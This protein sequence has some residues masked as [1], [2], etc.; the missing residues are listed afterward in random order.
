MSISDNR[1]VEQP[2]SSSG[3]YQRLDPAAI[4]ALRQPP[5]P[6]VYASLSITNASQ[7]VQDTESDNGHSG[8][9]RVFIRQVWLNIRCLTSTQASATRHRSHDRLQ[10]TTPTWSWF[11]RMVVIMIKHKTAHSRSKFVL[12]TAIKRQILKCLYIVSLNICSLSTARFEYWYLRFLICNL[13]LHFMY[14][15]VTIWRTW[16]LRT[17]K[18]SGVQNSGPENDGPNSRGGQCRTWY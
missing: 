6:S 13:L 15:A 11:P 1:T 9:T 7:G 10:T 2:A 17:K 18:S 8:T 14:R 12:A 4:A 16:H 3:V 5:V